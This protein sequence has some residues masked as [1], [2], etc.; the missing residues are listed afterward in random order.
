[1]DARMSQFIAEHEDMISE[2]ANG[3]S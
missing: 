1:M 2:V 3:T